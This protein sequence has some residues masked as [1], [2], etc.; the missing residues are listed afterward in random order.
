MVNQQ[1]RH[2]LSVPGAHF[3][4]FEAIEVSISLQ[5][6]TNSAAIGSAVSAAFTGTLH[7]SFAVHGLWG[8]GL[9]E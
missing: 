4:T 9:S 6:N 2:T 8:R 3:Y 7:A 1:S 5:L